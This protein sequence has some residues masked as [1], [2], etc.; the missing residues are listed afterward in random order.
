LKT[1]KG[2]GHVQPVFTDGSFEN[3][4]FLKEMT[5]ILRYA[6]VIFS[7][8]KVPSIASVAMGKTSLAATWPNAN[9]G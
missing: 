2:T 1:F 3:P 8:I 5:V 7:M 9:C 4:W 6:L